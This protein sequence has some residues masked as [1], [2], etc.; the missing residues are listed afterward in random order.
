MLLLCYYLKMVWWNIL[1]RKK[2]TNL[3]KTR[4]NH[5]DY[6][7]LFKELKQQPAKFSFTKCLL[8]YFVDVWSHKAFITC[9][10]VIV[11]SLYILPIGNYNEKRLE[12]HYSYV[13]AWKYKLVLFHPTCW[14]RPANSDVF[15]DANTSEVTRL[16]NRTDSHPM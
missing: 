9:K 11:D 13:H 7:R 10:Q 4:K 14:H 3:Y 8:L 1:S 6:V 2:R 15:S 12:I 5:S 16:K